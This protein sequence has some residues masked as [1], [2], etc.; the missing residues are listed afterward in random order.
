MSSFERYPRVPDP[1]PVDCEQGVVERRASKLR[2]G[3]GPSGVDSLA[4]EDWLLNFK[5]QSQELRKE[6]AAWVEWL[7]NNSPPWATIWALTT[8][9]LVALDK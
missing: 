4:L 9:C 7:S 1:I 3:A 2:R 6:V 8:N 5:C